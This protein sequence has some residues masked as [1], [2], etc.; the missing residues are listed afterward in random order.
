V[1]TAVE[2]PDQH[3]E[4]HADAPDRSLS[5]TGAR[6]PR[7]ALAV[8][9]FYVSLAPWIEVA[10]LVASSFWVAVPEPGALAGNLALLAL[11]VG[12]VLGL[13]AAIRLSRARTARR[14]M[15]F[16]VTAMVLPVAFFVLWGVLLVIAVSRLGGDASVL[17]R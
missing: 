16:A 3:G 2:H 14:G 13:V 12:F 10:L 7:D 17:W 1:A 8:A 5:A 9:A 6:P 4:R 11:P 15:G